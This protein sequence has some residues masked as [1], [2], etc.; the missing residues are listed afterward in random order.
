M[1]S[2]E[3]FL[4]KHL[5]SNK[6]NLEVSIKWRKKASFLANLTNFNKDC[7]KNFEMPQLP[8]LIYNGKK[9]EDLFKEL[10][11]SNNITPEQKEFAN[12][13]Y[14]EYPDHALKKMELI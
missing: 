7:L 14:R 1:G 4:A 3:Q 13:L 10:K 9:A 5:D 12:W 8:G 11:K 2:I 6:I